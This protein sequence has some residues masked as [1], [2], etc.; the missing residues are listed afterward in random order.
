VNE[1]LYVPNNSFL[2]VDYVLMYI[3]ASKMSTSV[4]QHL[5]NARFEFF[6]MLKIGVFWDV[7][8]SSQVENYVAFTVLTCHNMPE[9]LN[10]PR[11][12]YFVWY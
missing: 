7:M 6:T 8:P 4:K 12:V 9:D 3:S 5:F 10:L 2:C 11:L 1:H